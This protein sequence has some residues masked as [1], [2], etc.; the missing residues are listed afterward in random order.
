MTVFLLC[1][2]AAVLLFGRDFVFALFG[3]FLG[4]VA[5]TAALGLLAYA[6]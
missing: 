4:A 1:V 3:A 6:L 5:V 2:I